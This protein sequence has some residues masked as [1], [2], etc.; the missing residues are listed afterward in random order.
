MTGAD[1]S[2]LLTIPD[3][4]RL[5]TVSARTIE[6]LVASGQLASL[7]IGR[8]RRIPRTAI[9]EYVD[10]LLSEQANGDLE[11]LAPEAFRLAKETTAGQ[12]AVPADGRKEVVAGAGS[13]R[14]TG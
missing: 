5:L 8:A 3:C 4:A 12:G 2:M 1:D 11:P 7:R 10:R 9:T 6:S 14:P 13:H